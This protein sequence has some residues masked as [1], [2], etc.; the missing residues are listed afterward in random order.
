MPGRVSLVIA[1]AGLTL[2]SAAQVTAQA[3]HSGD[4]VAVDPEGR[5][6]TISELGSGA[7][8]SGRNRVIDRTVA[9]TPETRITL[10]ARAGADAEPEWPGGFG[11]TPIAAADLQKGDFATVEVERRGN[12]WIAVSVQVIRP[13]SERR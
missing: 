11:E 13:V 9:L 12:Q 3:K 2:A 5:S 7:R 6:I 8:G 4:V 1:F 10:V